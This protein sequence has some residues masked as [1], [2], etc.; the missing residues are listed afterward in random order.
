MWQEGHTA[1]AT[2]EE[3]QKETLQMLEIYKSIGTE[4][5]AIP[6]ITGQKTEKEK[7][8]RGIRNLYN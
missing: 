2:K 6:F 3:A 7:I 5:L 8:C 1:H 4:L